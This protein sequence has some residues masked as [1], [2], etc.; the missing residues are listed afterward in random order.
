MST[1]IE[2]SGRCANEPAIGEPGEAVQ[3]RERHLCCCLLGASLDTGNLGVSALAAS[4]IAAI[5]DCFPGAQI[6][7]VDYG[8]VPRTCEVMH[9]DRAVKVEL[10]NLRFSWKVLLPNNVLRLIFAAL[11][12]RLIPLRAMRAWLIRRNPYLLAIRESSII[13]SLAGGDSFSD[14]YGM[15]R[16]IYVGLPQILVLAMGK[17]LTVLPQ[18]LGPFKSRLARIFGGFI[19]RHADQ[20]YA[21]DQQSLEE[22][23]PLMGARRSKLRCGYDM[24]FRL[25][26]VAPAALPEW[27]DRG[28]RSGVVVGLNV[29]GLLYRGGYSQDNMFGLRAD[30]RELLRGLIRYFAIERGAEVVLIPHVLGDEASIESDPAACKSLLRE[31]KDLCPGK[32]W[33]VDGNYDQHQTKYLIGQCDFFL[34]SRMHACIAA[35]SQ[36]VP[37]VGLAYSRKFSGVLSSV[38]VQDLVVDLTRFDTEQALA[39]TKERFN[40]REAIRHELN[41]RMPGIRREVAGLFQRIWEQGHARPGGLEASNRA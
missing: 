15:R 9:E 24:A 18:T 41:R 4:S 8:K 13:G 16:L 2:V 5:L 26:A 30:Y 39:A 22:V 25:D 17:P 37:A 10:I 6:R 27:V 1:L 36:G 11:V 38:G 35:L 33:L 21:R 7:L 23:R 31:M 12:I 28:A 40:A 34:G 3:G 20:V 32:L 19:L 29:S 14:I